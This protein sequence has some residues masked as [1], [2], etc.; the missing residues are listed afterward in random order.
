MFHSPR[1]WGWASKQTTASPH[2]AMTRNA[3][4]S[5]SHSARQVKSSQRPYPPAT[6]HEVLEWGLTSS[7]TAGVT[8]TCVRDLSIIRRWSTH[9]SEPHTTAATG[10]SLPHSRAPS[11]AF[12]R[13][14]GRTSGLLVGASS[15]LR[16]STPLPSRRERNLSPC[17]VPGFTFRGP[18][19]SLAVLWTEIRGLP[20]LCSCR[21]RPF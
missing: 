5:D 9:G 16:G 8:V 14:P 6:P 12:H 3:M 21:L 20:R 13:G 1:K 4:C 17:S 11:R 18:P 2:P 19:Q 10:S 7:V 15:L